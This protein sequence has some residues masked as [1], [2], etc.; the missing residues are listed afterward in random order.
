MQTSFS[1]CCPRVSTPAPCTSMR[2][3]VLDQRGYEDV[4]GRFVDD[5]LRFR[6]RPSRGGGQGGFRFIDGPVSGG[7]SGAEAG[8]LTFMLGGADDDV[9]EAKPLHRDDGRQ[10]LPRRWRRR[11]SGREDR[12]QH[13]ARDQPAGCRRRCCARQALRPGPQGVLSISH[14]CH[15]A[16][17]GHCAPGTR[18]PVWRD[19]P[20]GTTT[21]TARLRHRCS[22]TRTSAWRSPA[23]RLRA[24]IFPPRQ[25]V[26]A[27]LQKLMDEDLGGL[28]TTALIKNIDPNAEGLPK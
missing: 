20:V 9:A 22:C 14:R 26:H 7:V 24:S 3:G 21:F 15:R 1:R 10:H 27:Q 19:V 23:P 18:C 8:T 2:D 28:D 6:T 17:P 25:L 11:R 12:Q 4:A 5:R 16:I 13:D